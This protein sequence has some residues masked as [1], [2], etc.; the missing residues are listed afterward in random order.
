MSMTVV[1][2]I[3]DLDAEVQPVLD[4]FRTQ[5]GRSTSSRESV[6]SQAMRGW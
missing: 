4:W 2:D 3:D 1:V 5:A 6:S